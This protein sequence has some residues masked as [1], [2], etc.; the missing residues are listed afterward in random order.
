MG[1]KHMREI[2]EKRQEKAFASFEDMKKRVNNLPD[3]EKA[4]ER[5]IIQELTEMERYNL[6]TH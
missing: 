4:I 6:F 2:L 5:R 3:P 1:K